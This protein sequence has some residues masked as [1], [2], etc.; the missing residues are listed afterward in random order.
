MLVKKAIEYRHKIERV[1]KCGIV[2]YC[3]I[4]DNIAA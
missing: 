1:F 3:G 2:V 4:K